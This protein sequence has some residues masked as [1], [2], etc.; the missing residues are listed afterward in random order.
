VCLCE[1]Y[2]CRCAGAF[3]NS[4][5]GA[6]APARSQSF[7]VLRGGGAPGAPTVPA[8][9]HAQPQTHLCGRRTLLTAERKE[10]LQRL[11]SE[12]P[13][14]HWQSGC[15]HGPSFRTS[16]MDLWLRQLGWR[17]KKNSVRRRQNG[18]TWPKKGLDAGA[19]GRGAR[20][21]LCLWMKAG[22]H[23]NDPLPQSALGGADGWPASRTTLAD[24]HAHLRHAPERSCAPWLFEAHERR[25]FGLARAG[26]APTLQK[27]TCILDNWHDKIQESSR[28]SQQQ[29]PAPVSAAL[30]TRLQPIEN[31][32][33]KISKSPQPSSPYGE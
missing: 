7:G 15:P 6:K 19:V 16:T 20:N 13:D 31:M 33:S 24:Q 1:P 22:Q 8:A 29:V 9:R 26:L 10:R 4:M 2:R 28:P 11:L 14:A 17:Y 27:G 5:N 25:C 3:C 21:R 32:C 18:R 23:Q 12:Q 30:F